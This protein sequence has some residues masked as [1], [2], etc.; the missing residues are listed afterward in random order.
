MSLF[1]RVLATTRRHD[2]IPPGTRVLAAVSGGADS[3]ALALTLARLAPGHGFA[4][5]AIAHLHHGLRG[6]EAD[7][8]QRFVEALAA[9]L[10]V[11]CLTA[12]ED[13][14]AR[15]A[16]AGESIETAA[17]R[18]RY[19]FLDAAASEARADRIATGH[20]ADDQ[21]ETV[22][23]RL[24][25]G[26]GLH[27][28]SAIRPRNGRVIRPLIEARR[29]AIEAFLRESGERWRDDA[30]N[31]DIAV[32]RN[33][34]RHEALPALKA[35]AGDGVVDALA[36][37]ASLIQDD[38]D[39][40]DRLAAELS[41]AAVLPDGALD[42]AVLAAASPALARRVIR[43]ALEQAA[44]GRFL[45]LEHVEAVRS[46]MKQGVAR[47]IQLPGIVASREGGCIR[48]EPAAAVGRRPAPFET[49]LPVPGSAGVPEAGLVM[50][51]EVGTVTAPEL[52]ALRARAD[53][54]AVQGVEPGRLTV[55]SRRPGDA[56]RPLGAPGRR[57]LQDVLV[58]KKIGR[59][60]RD[61]VPLV[62]D[63]R[64]RIIWVVGHTIADEFRVTSPEA[65]VLLLKVRRAVGGSV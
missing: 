40:L 65:S 23:M 13:V 51:A 58:D 59:E 8:D 4:L 25:R 19:A 36:R 38:A 24:M 57:K 11:P 56:L 62:V 32:A 46:L 53:A 43:A 44:D 10:G 14:A 9:R 7:E 54:V 12:R 30:S 50:S 33:R 45:S 18:L 34:V 2:L 49:S 15:A 55:R 1:E 37:T 64:G 60:E 21:A 3:V 41:A 6:P 61:R 22:V 20:T 63:D 48:I 28:L 52:T 5:A 26:A 27:G 31:A 29:S 39:E 47:R 17:R 42:M 35:I 16:E